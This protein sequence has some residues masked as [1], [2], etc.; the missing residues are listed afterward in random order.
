MRPLKCKGTFGKW[1]RDAMIDRDVN[2]R[3]LAA[4]LNVHCVSISYHLNGIRRPSFQM[5]KKYAN[6]FGVDLMDLYEMTIVGENR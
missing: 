1:L 5:L 3:E 6:Y 2:E 4:A